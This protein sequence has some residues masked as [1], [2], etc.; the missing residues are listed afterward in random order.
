MTDNTFN[1]AEQKTRFMSVDL[2]VVPVSL[3][4]CQ[5]KQPSVQHFVPQP[6]QPAAQTT[7]RQSAQPSMQNSE[8]GTFKKIVEK[9]QSRFKHT[10]SFNVNCNVCKVTPLDG[11]RFKCLWCENFNLCIRCMEN[12]EHFGHQFAIIYTSEMEKSIGD[13]M[14]QADQIYCIF[15]LYSLDSSIH[16]IYCSMYL[17]SFQIHGQLSEK[18]W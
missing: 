18:Q 4:A 14:Q 11:I 2:F 13:K 1:T 5:P 6:T 7:A 12:K 17:F 16:S 8:L 3:S 9:I 10:V 15:R